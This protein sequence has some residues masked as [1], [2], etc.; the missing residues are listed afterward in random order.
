MKRIISI[1]FAGIAAMAMSL[2]VDAQ[3]TFDG[4]YS[5]NPPQDNF[6]VKY[7]C[8]GETLTYGRIG[9]Y[10]IKRTSGE[11]EYIVCYD[12]SAKK[13]AGSENGS[14]WFFYDGEAD[15]MSLWRDGD[16]DPI[17][18][19]FDHFEEFFLSTLRAYYG[20][21]ER[22][23]YYYVGMETV[24]GVKC[25]VFDSKGLNAI[26]LKFWIDPSNGCCLKLYD[27]EDNEVDFE[28]LQYSTGYNTWSSDLMPADRSGLLKKLAE[29]DY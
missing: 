2:S 5:F 11:Y 13:L 25:W 3:Q 6:Y 21:I 1:V 14:E 9:D 15:E 28:V 17:E 19:V 12:Y 10:L 24:A 23:P 29:I 8:N 22:L 20:D 18:G 4:S 27:K 7:V 16:Y 26:Q